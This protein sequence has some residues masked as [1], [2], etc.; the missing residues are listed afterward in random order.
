MGVIAGLADDVLVDCAP[1]DRGA[2]GFRVVPVIRRAPSTPALLAA[3]PRLDKPGR[4]AQT[5]TDRA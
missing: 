4:S 1:N 2:G 5:D 3:T